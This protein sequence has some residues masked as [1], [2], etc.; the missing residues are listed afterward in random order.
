MLNLCCINSLEELSKIQKDWDNF[1]VIN[2]PYLYSKTY[3]WLTAW[4][5]SYEKDKDIFVY[6]LRDRATMKIVAALPLIIVKTNFGGFPVRKLEMIGRGIGCD[7]FPIIDF[8]SECVDKIFSH[9]ASHAK[10]HIAE[11]S[12][13]SNDIFHLIDNLKKGKV[14]NIITHSKNYCVDLTIGYEN[15]LAERSK[16]FR[17]NVRTANNRCKKYGTISYKVIDDKN[18]A[19]KMAKEI[20]IESWQYKQGSSHFSEIDFKKSF[21]ENLLNIGSISTYYFAFIFIDRTPMAYLFGVIKNDV[22]YVVDVSFKDTYSRFSPGMLLYCWVIKNLMSEKQLSV[23]D[24]GGEGEYKKVYSNM[25]KDEQ[26]IILYNNNLYASI[27]HFVRKQ[28]IYSKILRFLK[29]KYKK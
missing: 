10:W 5:L 2:F 18:I 3:N 27:I 26:K 20:A 21:M 4:C 22:F 13:I 25:I 28:K 14:Q 15:Y 19:F 17:Q 8:H 24:L 16:K 11:F 23:F 6:V 7:D 1:F 12:R 29:S 9:L